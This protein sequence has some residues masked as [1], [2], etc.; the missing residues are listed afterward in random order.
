MFFWNSFAFLMIQLMLAI[1]S[2]VPLPFLKPAWT[3]G[4]SWFTY[5]WSLAWRILSMTL[6]ATTQIS[7]NY[8]YITSLLSLPPLPTT[9]PSMSSQNI[10][11]GSLC[12]TAASH[13]LSSLHMAA[14]TCWCYFLHSPHSF[15]ALMC[16]YVHSLYLPL[17]SCPTNR[18]INTIFLDS[19]YM[20]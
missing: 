11:L 4:S 20:H 14:Y 7:R 19:I 6:L 9:Y 15:L 12:H 1:W 18:F 13:Q 17:H 8:A 3:S 10:R 2:L 16:P 5:C